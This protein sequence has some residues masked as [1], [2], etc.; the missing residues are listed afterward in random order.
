[1]KIHC[2][3]CG[4]TLTILIGDNERVISAKE[5]AEIENPTDLLCDECIEI[6]KRELDS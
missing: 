6:W 2:V 4:K 1:M 3:G 5:F